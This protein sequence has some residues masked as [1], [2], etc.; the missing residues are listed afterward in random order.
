MIQSVVQ[1]D[2]GIPRRNLSPC[3]PP[4][5]GSGEP[6]WSYRGL[7][8]NQGAVPKTAK[9]RACKALIGGSI[10]SRASINSKF[11]SGRSCLLTAVSQLLRSHV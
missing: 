9:G 2:S 7:N 6:L 3:N 8:Y 5:L 1:F 11:V 10:P 4:G